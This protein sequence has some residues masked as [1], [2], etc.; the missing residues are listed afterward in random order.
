MLELWIG[1]PAWLRMLVG[2]GLMVLG[3]LIVYGYVVAEPRPRRLPT[4]GALLFGTGLVLILLGS[5]SDAEK[6]GYRF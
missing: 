6:N 5:K 4:F 1:L 3:G 2:L